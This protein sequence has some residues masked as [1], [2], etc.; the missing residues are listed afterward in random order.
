MPDRRI[1][2]LFSRA[3]RGLGPLFWA[4]KPAPW[5]WSVSDP[6]LVL[7]LVLGFSGSFEDENED[8]DEDEKR[9]SLLSHALPV[10]YR[11]NGGSI[12]A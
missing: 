8:E 11:L 9:E 5:P 2:R 10:H 1:S 6:R 7:V 4:P 3:E 12:A